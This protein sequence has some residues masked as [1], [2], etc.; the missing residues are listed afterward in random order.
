MPHFK[1]FLS[2]TKCRPPC[3]GCQKSV[4]NELTK[5]NLELPSQLKITFPIW[6]LQMRYLM[7]LFY[8]IDSRA[9]FSYSTVTRITLFCQAFLL[10]DTGVFPWISCCVFLPL[11]NFLSATRFP[12]YLSINVVSV[13]APKAHFWIF[14][15]N[16]T[17]KFTYFFT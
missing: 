12:L 15:E 4:T 14:S 13:C 7:N 2:A 16:K 11:H 3:T 6:L 5:W 8:K 9:K 10:K 1:I 17:P